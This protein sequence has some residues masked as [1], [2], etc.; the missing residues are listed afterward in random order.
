MQ[1]DLCR[2]IKSDGLQCRA[3]ALT[4]AHFC[5]F[6]QRL[7]RGHDLYRSTMVGKKSL[8]ERGHIIAL[9]PLEDRVSI[10]LALSEVINALACNFIDIPRANALL[11]GLKLAAYNARGLEIIAQPTAVVHTYSPAP[12]MLDSVAVDLAPPGLTCELDDANDPAI[13]LDPGL[14]PGT[15]NQRTI[16][17]TPVKLPPQPTAPPQPASTPQPYSTTD[18]IPLP[19]CVLA[20]LNAAFT[21]PLPLPADHSPLGPTSNLEP[22]TWL[23]APFMTVPLS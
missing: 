13:R 10:Q 2:H 22:G 23:G 11:H 15:Y 5:Y 18:Q 8:M 4:D 12:G 7:N 3:I 19:E 14:A 6:H 16:S 20:A 1:Y 21:D 9:P 17:S